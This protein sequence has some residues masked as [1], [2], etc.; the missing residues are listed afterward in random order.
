M[1][2]EEKGEKRKKGKINKK[3]QNNL[4]LC[5]FPH[6]SFLQK[7]Y[8]NAD[9]FIKHPG[10]HFRKLFEN[11]EMRNSITKMVWLPAGLAGLILL[12]GCQLNQSIIDTENLQPLSKEKTHVIRVGFV[13]NP[14]YRVL[15]E[16]EKNRLIHEVAIKTRK[17][18]G[19]RVEMKRIWVKTSKEFYN[20][21]SH[22]DEIPEMKKLLAYDIDLSSFESDKILHDVSFRLL[23]KHGAEKLREYIDPTYLNDRSERLALLDQFFYIHNQVREAHTRKGVPVLNTAFVR[24]HSY[25]GMDI[26]LRHIKDVDLVF[27]N[28]LIC[29]PDDDMPIYYMARG[30]VGTGAVEVNPHNRYGGSA[31]VS[32]YPFFPVD[33]ILDRLTGPIPDLYRVE[34]AAAY[35]V[36][37]LGH[38]L[39]RRVEI[40]DHAHCVSR[41]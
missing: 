30:A 22:L 19:Y 38:L 2:K 9:V 16:G 28:N 27:T 13:E 23:K 7:F 15:S 29:I 36:H 10:L 11:P 26:I 5:S 25:W 21:Y 17:Q 4:Y 18:L 24:Q 31:F 40:Y 6:F 35:T 37:E 8:A 39:D 20:D 33:G 14:D 1:C 41:A 34:T 3:R 32:L 12:A